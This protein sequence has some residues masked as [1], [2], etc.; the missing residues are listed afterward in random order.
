M[1]E[2][3]EDQVVD[4][5]ALVEKVSEPVTITTGFG[6]RPKV[7]VTIMDDSGEN[8]TASSEFTA[9]FPKSRNEQYAPDD[10]LQKLLN[11]VTSRKPVA[12]FNLRAQKSAG[13]ASEHASNSK[14]HPHNKQRKV[15]HRSL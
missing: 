7:D 1:L 2:C 10:Q 8:S 4:V 5:A 9:W 14:N 11:S 13:S 12:F 15:Q 6:D 3:H